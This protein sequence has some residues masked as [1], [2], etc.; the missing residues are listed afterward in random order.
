MKE[1]TPSHIDEP[2]V[3]ESV[4]KAHTFTPASQRQSAGKRRYQPILYVIAS[5]LI[6]ALSVLWFIFTAKSLVITTLPISDNVQ[7]QGG[8]HVQWGDNLLVTP[9]TYTVH[10]SQKGY[11]PFKQSF[12]VDEQQ[13]QLQ[14]FVFK[15]L[16]GRLTLDIKPDVI[17]NVY[18]D[19]ELTELDQG[20]IKSVAAG[21]RTLTVKADNYFPFN[22]NVIIEGK[23]QAQSLPVELIPA[24]GNV[25]LNSTPLGAEVYQEDLLL[26]ATPLNVELI[27]GSHQLRFEKKGYRP[28]IREVNILA[29]QSAEFKSVTLFKA[30]G[31]MAITSKPS[32][33]NIS[34][35]EQ[36][37]GVTPLSVSVN[38]KKQQEL[39]LFKE[40][41][42]SQSHIIN[43]LPGQQVNKHFTL[44]DDLG[45]IAFNVSPKGALLYLND[46][47][48]GRAQTQLSLPIKQHNIRIESPGF[49]SYQAT[50]LPQSDM[51]QRLDISL[52]TLEQA[53]FDN[54]QPMITADVGS[55]LKLFK[56]NDVIVMGASRREQGRRANEVKRKVQ[57]SRAFYL[58]VTEITNKQF[59][60]F[61][62]QH[63]SGHV[64]GNSLNGTHQPAV[65]L[66]WQQAALFCNWLSERDN[67]DKVYLI[68]DDKIVDFDNNANG[69]RLPTEA[70]WVWASRFQ[71]GQMLKYSWGS[72]LPPT[73]NSGNF[74]DI[75]GAPILGT[76]LTN[77]NDKY[78]ATA[79]VA[80]FT[81]NMHGIFD[82]SGN[83][84]E[85][86]HDYYQ[87]QTGLSQ[88]TEQD[89]MGPKTG[90]YHVIRG[91]S[92]AHGSRTELRLSF[93]DYGNDKRND[94]GFRLARNAL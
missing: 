32:G 49:V 43:I 83:V 33:V 56:P 15:R 71:K 66:T 20:V 90:D 52:K 14:H 68:E 16:P 74:A 59:R 35:G 27:Q 79:P 81:E 4:I 29:G 54:M 23:L 92:W 73:E 37:L 87:I 82:L 11:Y 6:L 9:G 62:R 48:M 30:M 65:K 1:I 5:L 40:G 2:E 72:T 75:S 24:W 84:S 93:R 60:Q 8:L 21:E 42:Q 39:L 67:L 58:G 34:Y 76:V 22:A 80:S 89:P 85:W 3:T 13:N 31:V 55:Q 44:A 78:V 64:N 47:L 50:I 28:S 38:P 12:L 51:E 53:K 77:Y 61:Q 46:R 26:G 41:Y 63:S 7:I 70:E 91:S 10:A 86:L 57:I 17:N 69:Y 19:G 36:F 94:L 18:I 45:E 88:K 25:M